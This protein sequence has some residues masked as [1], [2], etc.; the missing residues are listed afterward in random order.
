[1]G[2][3]TGAH[4]AGYAFL[5]LRVDDHDEP[6]GDRSDG[7]ESVLVFRVV[8]IEDLE[9]LVARPEEFRCL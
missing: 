2:C 8:R 5:G 9:V 4:D 3:F 6:A 7:D 1:M